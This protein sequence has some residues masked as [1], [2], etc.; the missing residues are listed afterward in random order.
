MLGNL[1]KIYSP[2]FDEGK[3]KPRSIK[4]IILHY[5]GMKKEKYALDRLTSKHSKVSCHYFITYSGEILNMVPDLYI[6][7][8]AGKS[9]W[10]KKKSLNYNSIGIEISNPGH[11]N[12]YI[13]F[14]KKQLKSILFLVSKLKKKYKIEN[15]N[16]LGH[17][18]I[19]P[20][21]K[22][23]PGE[24]FPWELMKKKNIGIW[25]NLSGAKLRKVRNQT[26]TKLEVHKF[27]D[28]LKKIGY[29]AKSKIKM[30]EA[31]QRRFRQKQIS[32]KID[33]ECLLISI[34]LVK[35]NKY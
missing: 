34:S 9:C 27:F 25:H 7:W 35:L 18:D 30:V 22:K 31:F 8:H 15:R 3:R 5:T 17:S 12:N 10:K 14:R 21:R 11:D 32:D 16:I 26:C 28:N 29:R 6:S 23:D 4:F 20:D 1:R 33:K 24:K 13:N 19:A 2:N